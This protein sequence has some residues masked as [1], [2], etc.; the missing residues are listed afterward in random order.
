MKG[1]AV[2]AFEVVLRTSPSRT[3]GGRSREFCKCPAVQTVA[4]L[5]AVRHRLLPAVAWLY[6][7]HGNGWRAACSARFGPGGAGTASASDWCYFTCACARQTKRKPPGFPLAKAADGRRLGQAGPTPMGL[8]PAAVTPYL[9]HVFG[10]IPDAS[11]PTAE[12]LSARLR[13]ADLSE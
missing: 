1:K 13:G 10:A 5:L 2:R 11:K 4:N 3:V 12:D 9:I 6:E 8:D 7:N